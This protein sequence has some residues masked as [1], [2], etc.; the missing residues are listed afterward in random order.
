MDILLVVGQALEYRQLSRSIKLNI[1]RNLRD[2]QMCATRHCSY[3][4]CK[5]DSRYAN[6]ENMDGVFWISFPKP[7]QNMDKCKF[8]A[9]A[10]GREGFD[11]TNVNKW[12]YICSKHFVGGRGPTEESPNPFPA[13]FSRVRTGIQYQ[14]SPEYTTLVYYN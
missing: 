3:G 12:T 4:T 1:N 2:I 8:W 13:R 7:K 11:E 5:S 10:C 14:Q 6:R 9:R